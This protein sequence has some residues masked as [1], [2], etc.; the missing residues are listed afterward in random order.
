MKGGLMKILLT[1]GL[2]F[3]AGVDARAGAPFD[4]AKIEALTGLKGQLNEKDG[5]FKVSYPRDDIKVVV[6]GVKMTP[7][8]GL[9]AWAAFT[10]MGDHLMAMGD[11]VLLEDQVNAVMSA[12]LENGLEAP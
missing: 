2:L 4:T 7:P 12:A 10:P 3:V 8:M 11:I 5:V 6:A 9:T 1:L